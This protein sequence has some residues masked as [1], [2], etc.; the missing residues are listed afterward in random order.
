MRI[1]PSVAFPYQRRTPPEGIEIASQWI[2]GSVL[3]GSNA[4]VIHRDK[5]VFGQ[6]AAEFRPERWLE[7]SPEQ[8]SLMNRH[9]IQFGAGSRTC[10][11]KNISIVVS[12]GCS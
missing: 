2:P 10:L 4:F 11:G 12:C 5:S 1:W 7:S 9:M 8:I 3:V 6:D